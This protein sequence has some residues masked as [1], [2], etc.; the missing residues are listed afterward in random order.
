MSHYPRH[1]YSILIGS[2]KLFQNIR[3]EKLITKMSEEWQYIAKLNKVPSKFS[4]GLGENEDKFISTWNFGIKCKG[5]HL[6]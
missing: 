1:N 2:L 3:S 5:S 6:G 4:P